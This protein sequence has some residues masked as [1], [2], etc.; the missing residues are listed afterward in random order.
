MS[1]LALGLDVT[2]I[3]LGDTI[4]PHLEAPALSAAIRSAPCAWT[5][6]GRSAPPGA[7]RAGP[8]SS[9]RQSTAGDVERLA[10]ALLYGSSDKAEGT[11]AFLDKR[12][13]EF[14]GE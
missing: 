3:E 9:A 13:P 10:Q 8:T 5:S 14:K 12:T 2:V 11:E 6:T 7:A 4:L 1:L